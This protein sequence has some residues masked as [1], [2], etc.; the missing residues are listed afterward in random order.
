MLLL[1]GNF[2]LVAFLSLPKTKIQRFH[3][4]VITASDGHSLGHI[5]NHQLIR[6]HFSTMGASYIIVMWV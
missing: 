3:L 2:L 1:K 4:T 6:V 5:T